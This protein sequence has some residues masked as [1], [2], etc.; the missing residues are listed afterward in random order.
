MF[1]KAKRLSKNTIKIC[2]LNYISGSYSQRKL[3]RHQSP[4]IQDAID[5][6]KNKNAIWFQVTSTVMPAN[7]LFLYLKMSLQM[8]Q[9][10]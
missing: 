1:D 10:V 3:P 5:L 9:E 7:F 8:C 6:S 2:I 4:I